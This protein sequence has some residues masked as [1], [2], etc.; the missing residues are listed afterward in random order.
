V[1]GEYEAGTE[2]AG[3]CL[4]IEAVTFWRLR[5]KFRF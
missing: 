1:E 3:G 5:V 4:G 2:M